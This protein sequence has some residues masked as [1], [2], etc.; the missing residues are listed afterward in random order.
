MDTI[1]QQRPADRLQRQP[2]LPRAQPAE[3]VWKSSAFGYSFFA[4]NMTD[5]YSIWLCSSENGRVMPE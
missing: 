4:Q 3:G 2:G 5:K 1:K